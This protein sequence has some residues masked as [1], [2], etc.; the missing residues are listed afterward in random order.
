MSRAELKGCHE[1]QNLGAVQTYL[2]RYLWTT[3]FEVVEHDALDATTGNVEVKSNQ[4]QKPAFEKKEQIKG[5][6]G[7]WQMIANEPPEGDPSEWLEVIGR[8][9]ETALALATSKDDV[10]DIFKKNKTLFDTVKKINPE[11][12][13]NLMASFTVA[14]QKFEG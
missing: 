14:K 12:F 1:V 5:K 9:A 4:S 2:R 11:F 6:E 3:A 7:S 13:T 10:M 8:T